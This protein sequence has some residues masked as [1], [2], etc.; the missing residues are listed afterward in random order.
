MTDADDFLDLADFTGLLIDNTLSALIESLESQLQW[1][2]QVTALDRM[3]DDEIYN[4]LS[5]DDID[6]WLEEFSPELPRLFKKWKASSPKSAI[7]LVT[8]QD[9]ASPLIDAFTEINADIPKSLLEKKVVIGADYHPLLDSIKL[10]L[11]F[12]AKQRLSMMKDMGLPAL[13][14][15]RVEI[16]SKMNLVSVGKE[17]KKTGDSHFKGK[18]LEPTGKSRTVQSPTKR[19]LDFK[20]GADRKA[21]GNRKKQKKETRIS[22]PLKGHIIG[23]LSD[24]E[25]IRARI[26]ATNTHSI[27][28]ATRPMV[29]NTDTQMVNAEISI[30][31]RSHFF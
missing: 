23:K 9:L 1:R 2:E 26:P 28:I 20:P 13:V 29:Q 22:K 19:R 30:V 12:A 6:E 8:K 31:L 17:I 5:D 7:S 21:I 11:V 15:E 16:K 4:S 18:M 3:N 10:H 27:K 24:L 25:R 14:A